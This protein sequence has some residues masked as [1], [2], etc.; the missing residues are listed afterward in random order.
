MGELVYFVLTIFLAVANG[1]KGANNG[2]RIVEKPIAFPL[3]TLQ[4][5]PVIDPPKRSAGYFKLDRTQV[6]SND[7]E[8][9]EGSPL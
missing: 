9:P 8:K 7:S 2:P 4:G 1:A 5:V 6:S 3:E